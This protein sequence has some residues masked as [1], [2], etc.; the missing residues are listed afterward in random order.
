MKGTLKNKI[1]ILV[2]A[3]ALAMTFPPVNAWILGYFALLP[4]L[5]VFYMEPEKGF[6]RG[7]FF[8]FI[9]SLVLVHWLAFNSG[10]SVWLVTLSALMAAAFLALNYGVM[11]WITVLYIRRHGGLG[12]FVFPIVWTVV[13]FI[14]SFGALG[15]QWVLVA[16]GQTANLPF[17]QMADLGGPFLISFLLVS[18]NTLLFCL[19]MKVPAYRGIWQIFYVLL[20]IFLIV[21]YTYG[22]FR[23]YQQNEPAK[24]HVFRL[25][26]PDYDSH[27]KWER[28]RRDEI[29]DTMISLSRAPGVDSVDIIVW[30]ESATPVYIRTQIKYRSMLEELSRETGCVLISG[31]PDY[32]VRNG[33]VYVT[34]SLYV[35]EPQQ[36]ISGKYNKQ[37]LVPFGEYIPLSDVFPRLSRLNLGQGNF[38]AG[39]NEP[40]L[41]V[42]SLDVTLA[43]MICYESVFS[44]EALIKIRN[45]GEYHILVT[46]DSWFGDSWG[47]YQ[48]ASQA[49]FRAV[50]TRRP[51]IRCANTG[52]SMA[53][54]H[55][56]RILKEL[57]LNTRGIL[58]VRMTVPDMQS[59]YVKSGNTFA[60]ILCGVLMG[61]LLTPLWPVK[62]NRNDP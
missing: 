62:R 61:V 9:Y 38:T 26:Q 4:L 53:I 34:N 40:L 51:V 46:N 28:E 31:V 37:K 56:G 12:L 45:G 60:F 43:P 35:F 19:L 30:P 11:G 5:Y 52:V 33:K 20:G 39:K 6:A 47:P 15:F 23:L 42:D 13:E 3:L 24:S 16:N 29:F 14:R 58:D 8:G 21:P 57:P 49:I 22:I 18:V 54:D 2:S 25:V 27:E 50:E 32:F 44:R 1:L 59:P 10:A 55:T 17:I 36:G 41:R 48:H 7:Y